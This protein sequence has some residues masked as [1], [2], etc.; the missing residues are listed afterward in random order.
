[1]LLSAGFAQLRLANGLRSLADK[2]EPNNFPTPQQ[3]V[4]SLPNHAW[5][6]VQPNSSAGAENEMFPRR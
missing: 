4:I 3:A 2:L 5:L 6:P 1:M